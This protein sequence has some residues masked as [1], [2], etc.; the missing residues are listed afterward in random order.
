M[1]D[2]LNPY[3]NGSAA[4]KQDILVQFR[5]V[6]KTYDGNDL[7][8]RNLDLDVRK[9]EFL[10]LLGPSGSGKTTT[11]MMLAGFESPSDGSIW[12]SGNRIDTL[13]PHRRGIGVVFQQY[14]LF[15]HMTVAENVAYPLL[16]RK[17]PKHEIRDKVQNALE[18]VQLADF[19]KRKPSQLSG[20][21]QQ[22]VALSRALVFEPSIVLMD[23][24]LGALDR[25]LRETLQIEIRRIHQ[26]LKVTIVYVT[27]DQNEA[28]TMSDRIAVYRNGEISQID[29]PDEIYGNPRDSYVA[30]FVGE[31]NL[32]PGVVT[33]TGGDH[34]VQVALDAGAPAEAVASGGAALLAGQRI[35]ASVRPENVR[36]CASLDDLPDTCPAGLN[37]LEGTVADI[38]FLGEQYRLNVSLSDGQ[39]FIVKLPISEASRFAV[40]HPIVV[41]WDRSD[42]RILEVVSAG[43]DT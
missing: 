25:K 34:T 11:L 23:E 13:P 15:P 20:G 35:A 37:R 6:S 9:G 26:E 12:L 43:G 32:L 16:C 21:Q 14:A 39:A 24:P 22:R 42:L 33:D 8:V 7:A 2:G 4:A 40:G 30:T 29:T 36:A 28:L 17:A 31:S 19:A 27:H 18:L 5:N 10:T 41:Y 3:G 38:M 1:D